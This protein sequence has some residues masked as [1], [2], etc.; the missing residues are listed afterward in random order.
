LTDGSGVPIGLAVE[1][2]NTHDMRMVE[3]TLGSVPV[4]RPEP[5]PTKKQHLCSDKGYDDPSER[6]TL[7]EWV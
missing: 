2:A 6:Q 7:K 4:D 5:R 1:G 3:A